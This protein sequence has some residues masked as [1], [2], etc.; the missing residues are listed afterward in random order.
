MLQKIARTDIQ[1][2]RGKF[3]KT[4]GM[5]MERERRKTKPETQN[6]RY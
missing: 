3:A 2:E 1:T 4:A 5:R 6:G